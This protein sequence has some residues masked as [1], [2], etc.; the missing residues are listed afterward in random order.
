MAAEQPIVNP[1]CPDLIGDVPA[2]R[3]KRPWSPPVLTREN[4]TVA[5]AT[6]AGK[7]TFTREITTAIG[8]AS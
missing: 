8:H 1:A 7:I 4:P 5:G 6:N 3:A 2:D